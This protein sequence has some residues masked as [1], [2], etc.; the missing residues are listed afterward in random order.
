MTILGDRRVFG[1]S[2]FS[3][4]TFQSSEQPRCSFR[5]LIT[6]GLF[7]LS[8]I[9]V[10]D[11]I[12]NCIVNLVCVKIRFHTCDHLSF[13]NIFLHQPFQSTGKTYLF[14]FAA[15]LDMELQGEIGRHGYERSQQ[16]N[17]IKTTQRTSQYS[18]CYMFL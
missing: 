17:R 16:R 8:K 2:F 5:L 11:F 6:V 12:D 3:P 9:V 18:P 15:N 7:L 10:E 13:L 1:H 4:I 14:H